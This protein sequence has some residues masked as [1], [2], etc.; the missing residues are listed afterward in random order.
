[1]IDFMSIL[2]EYP[3]AIAVIGGI[4]AT[5]ALV[6]FLARRTSG[7]ALALGGIIVATLLLL[8][9]ERL[10]VT[11]REQVESNVGGLLAAV[12]ANDLP[13]VLSFIDP[14]G[15]GVRSDAQTLMS[16]VKV[17]KA[18][19]IG[20]LETRLDAVANPP[21]ARVSLHGFLD[22]VHSSTGMHIG[23]FN[24][25]VDVDW[26]KRGER[27]LVDDY[28]AYYNG[29]PINAVGSARSRRPMPGR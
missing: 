24:Q 15:A 20:R 22:G 21:A 16:L 8:V 2:V 10:V 28:T 12:E 4:A 17:I 11:D 9:V 25:Q 6:V 23:Y 29:Q 19:A 5:L 13:G 7:A 3:V 1:M 18:R 27:W 26:V 14:A